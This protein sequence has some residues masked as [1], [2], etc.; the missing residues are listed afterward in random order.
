MRPELW[1]LA[2]AVLATVAALPPTVGLAVHCWRGWRVTREVGNGR[3][4]VAYAA[5]RAALLRIA[6]VTLQT[7]QV[8]LVG[9][10][11]WGANTPVSWRVAAFVWLLAA[12]QALAAYDV[13]G[14][15]RSR[16]RLIRAADTSY[17]DLGG[18]P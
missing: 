9:V 14:Q 5:L 3:R 12:A 18:L 8:A 6:K 7:G 10:I 1:A 16:V 15:L 2:F 4:E 11:L 17:R 13:W